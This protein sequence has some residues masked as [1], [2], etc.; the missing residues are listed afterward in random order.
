MS[1][2]ALRLASCA[3]LLSAC[4][5][6]PPL[7]LY[8]PPPQARF[9]HAPQDAS[10]TE[11]VGAFWQGFQD[12]LLDRLVQRALDANPDVRTAAASL[13]EARAI[14]RIADANLL[15]TADVAAGAARVRSQDDRGIPS[16]RNN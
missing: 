12:P 14:S 8:Q 10:A 11:P 13:R 7:K 6:A 5:H 9:V 4:S 16:T 1:T 3:V 2:I 15:P